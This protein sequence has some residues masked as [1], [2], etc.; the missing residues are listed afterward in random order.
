VLDRM[1]WPPILRLGA[2]L[3]WS[4]WAIHTVWVARYP[5]P[6]GTGAEYPLS[7]VLVIVLELGLATYI[8]YFTIRPHP[9][10]DLWHRAGVSLAFCVLMTK[11]SLREWMTD[12]PPYLSV[13]ST[14]AVVTTVVVLVLL[15]LTAR[16]Q[17]RR[18]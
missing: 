16:G 15:P 8:L 2:L 13:A 18:R 17:S 9:A 10:V 14:Y 6:W 1:T 4:L 11:Y 7:D 5:G 12:Q 3:Y